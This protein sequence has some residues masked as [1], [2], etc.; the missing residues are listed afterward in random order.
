MV[1]SRRAKDTI[2]TYVEKQGRNLV[3]VQLTL[4]D[5]EQQGEYSTFKPIS[6]AI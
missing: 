6:G 3:D 5:L 4:F 2:L 1:S